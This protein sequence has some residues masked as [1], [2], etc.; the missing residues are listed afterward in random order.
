MSRGHLGVSGC[1]WALTLASG[2]PLCKR[3]A[4]A[5]A[6][7]AGTPPQ[8]FCVCRHVTQAQVCTPTQGHAQRGVALVVRGAACAGT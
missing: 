7:A 8:D 6:L 2:G 4:W 1:T 5:L 3:Y